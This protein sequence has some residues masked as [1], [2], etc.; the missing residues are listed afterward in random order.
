MWLSM[1]VFVDESGDAGMKDRPGTSSF[2][3]ICAVLFFENADAQ[4]C[5]AKIE[6]L[7]AKCFGGSGREFKFNKCCAE[8]RKSFL[9]AMVGQEFLYLGFVLNKCKLYGP[10][11]QFKESFYKYTCKLLFEN[12]KP[13]LSNAT[14]IID[15]SGERDFRRELQA[16]LKKKINTEGEIIR[17]VKIEASHKNN[18]LQLAD[19]V[20]GSLARSFRKDKANCFEYRSIIGRKEMKVQ[21]WPQK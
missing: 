17:K 20:V 11:F 16:Y 13:Y 5:D 18:L 12:A 7:R 21:T 2:F 1:L 15:G 6:E 4:T 10:G 8:H 9:Q 3:V 19:M 14:V